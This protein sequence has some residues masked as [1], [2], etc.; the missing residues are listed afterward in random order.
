[1]TTSCR[2]LKLVLLCLVFAWLVATGH[3]AGV[4]ADAGESADTHAPDAAAWELAKNY[5]RENAG[6]TLVVMHAG[7]IIFEVY[8]NGGS[9][10]KPEPIAS[11]SKG[12]VGVAAIAAVED[13]ILKLDD[14]ACEAITQWA[15]DPEKS[16][17]TYRQL[18]TLTSGIRPR[19]PGGGWNVP[20]WKEVV[21]FPLS[22]KPG[23]QFAYGE[24][25]LR[26]S[27]W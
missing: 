12:F 20:S 11:G 19:S 9:A 10:G 2:L 15:G 22:G 3:A 16:K 13:G 26:M 14:P 18:L 23:A 4:A 7:T 8:A 17:I 1:M 25:H 27:L 6:K 21:S 24:V 5:H